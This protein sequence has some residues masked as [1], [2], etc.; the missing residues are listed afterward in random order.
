VAEPVALAILKDDTE[1]ESRPLPLKVT[2]LPVA[3]VMAR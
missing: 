3:G 2:S 1:P